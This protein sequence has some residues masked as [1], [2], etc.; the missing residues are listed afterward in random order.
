M[1]RASARS[2]PRQRYVRV[3]FVIIFHDALSTAR[4]FDLDQ[5]QLFLA[6]IFI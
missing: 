6:F 1:D 2:R 5:L 4:G 3:S